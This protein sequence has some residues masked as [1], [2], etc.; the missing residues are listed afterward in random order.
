MAIAS[1]LT[2]FK[3]ETGSINHETPVLCAVRYH[4]FI[5]SVLRLN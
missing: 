3:I 2:I 5:L 4:P 1:R